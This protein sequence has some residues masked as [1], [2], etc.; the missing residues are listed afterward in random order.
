MATAAPATPMCKAKMN[1]GSRTIFK[2][3]PMITEYMPVFAKPW[4]MMNW[5][6]PVAIRAKKVPVR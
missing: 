1:T 5:F 2:T 4:E 3:A 6:I